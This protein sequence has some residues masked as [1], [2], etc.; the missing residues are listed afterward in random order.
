MDSSIPPYVLERARQRGIAI[1]E[2]IEAYFGGEKKVIDLEYLQ[3]VDSFKEWVEKNDVKP[4]ML[5]EMLT[6]KEYRGVIDMLAY[7]RN[8]LT[9][10]SFKATAK[11]NVPYCEL[12][13]SAYQQLLL[14]LGHIDVPVNKIA[15]H[16]TKSGCTEYALE[17]KTEEFNA[18]IM[19]DRYLIERGVI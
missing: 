10:V 14:E 1:H 16:I 5:E 7:V 9:L 4:L 12:Q 6:G 19:L 17:D 13:E 2:W 15:L 8:E 18:L 3:Y 11:L